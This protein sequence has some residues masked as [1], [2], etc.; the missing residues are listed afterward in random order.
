MKT[1][2]PAEISRKVF[3]EDI[4]DLR[5]RGHK[6]GYIL[7]H[8]AMLTSRWGGDK[9]ISAAGLSIVLFL[10]WLFA[11]KWVSLLWAETLSFW[12]EV[13]GM[14][15]Y[16]SM[17][18]YRFE[19]VY[20]FSA[21]YLHFKSSVPDYVDLVVGAIITISVFIGT[22]F[23]PRRHLP[24]I[25]SLRVIV[26]F[27]AC[28]QLFFTFVPLSFPYGASGYVHGLL[29]AGLA[30]IAV[31]P[32][33]LAFT[34]YIF[35]FRF[36][37]K[38]G[39]TLMVMG[40]FIIMIP[41]QFLAH[42]YILYH[43][44]LLMLPLLFF[45]FGLPMNVMIFIGY[46]SWGASWKNTL[47]V[48]PALRG[49]GFFEGRRKL[50]GAIAL[51]L[52]ILVLVIL[53]SL[54]SQA[55]AQESAKVDSVAAVEVDTPA[56]PEEPGV[57]LTKYVEVGIGY[58]YFT[59]DVGEGNDQF[60]AFILAREQSWQLRLDGGR[61]ER[62]GDSGYGIGA[63]F[64]KYLASRWSVAAG[65]NTGSGEFIFPE[66]RVSAMV[67]V[68]LLKERNLQV[69]LGYVH[70]Q[71]KGENYFDRIAASATWYSGSHWI[72]GGYF[73]YDIGEPGTTIT[74][75]GGLGATWFNWQKRYIGFLVEY[76]DINYTQVG[77]T[78]FLVGYEQF[79][80][81]G[82]FSEYFDPTMG[83]NVRAEYATNE[84]WDMYAVAVSLFKS[85]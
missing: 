62:W 74:A 44:S 22:F 48:E 9:L 56:E 76:G 31:V 46:Y 1:P 42:A 81:R 40:H 60:A 64:T 21:P 23:I 51:L 34:Y 45:V 78:D 66:Y 10:A 14:R 26:F 7:E 18:H 36:H 15:A 55:S 33:I 41:L 80:I 79:L 50:T 28:A 12:S 16:V 57:P 84:I 32:V 70:D 68:A 8:R 11:M 13:L 17:V 83:I 38:V 54:V 4:H 73:N 27:Q 29:I 82:T 25:Y 5:R 75:S 19:N 35:D 53:L 47:Y 77:A 67:G 24:L 65:A 30:L 52:L 2:K 20:S 61:A 3:G 69:T 49:N 6:G 58:S 72:Y 85:W 37:K 59:N 43:S 63:M 71:S 39:L